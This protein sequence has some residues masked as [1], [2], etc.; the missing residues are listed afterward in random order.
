MT[1]APGEPIEAPDAP[2]IRPE[3]P[4]PPAPLGL[5]AILASSARLVRH[6]RRQTLLPLA[7]TMLPFVWMAAIAE[8]VLLNNIYTDAPYDSISKVIEDAPP[9]LQAAL[10][11]VSWIFALFSLVGF[12]ATVVA[13][14]GAREGRNVP[15]SQA[16]DPAFTR[17][18]GLFA[19]GALAFALWTLAAVLAVT[20]I[21]TALVL[22]VML[23][24]SLSVHAFI[25]DGTGVLDSCR[26]SWRVARGHLMRVL[27][28]FFAT[29]PVGLLAVF[30]ALVL[31]VIVTIPFTPSS[32]GRQGTL[33]IGAVG[34]SVAGVVLVP[35]AAFVAAATTMLYTELR[36][37]E[38]AGTGPRN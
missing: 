25:L 19:L 38:H 15:L 33:A 36:S 18:G 23:R 17:M 4:P 34:V 26:T 14:H 10:A 1:P 12:A 21:G 5:G 30:C 20:V 3:I 31:A 16:L 29:I 2:G 35:F 11:G 24:L 7:V 37:R 32:P 8:F 28:L 9:G 27:G 6:N 13:I 22:F